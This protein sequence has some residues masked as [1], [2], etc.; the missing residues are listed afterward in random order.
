[1]EGASVAN[2]GGLMHIMYSADANT[3]PNYAP[4]ISLADGLKACELCGGGLET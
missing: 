4:V 2:A 3:A 1:M